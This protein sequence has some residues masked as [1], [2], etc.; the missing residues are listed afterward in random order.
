MGQDRV[1]ERGGQRVEDRGT[2]LPFLELTI[3]HRGVAVAFADAALRHKRMEEEFNKRLLPTCPTPAAL[4]FPHMQLAPAQYWQRNFFSIL[5]LSIFEA[6]GITEQRQHRYGMLLHGVRGIVTATDNVLDDEGKGSVLLTLRGGKVLK[7]VLVIL[8]ET[9]ILHEVL[10]D[11]CHDRE[12]MRDTWRGLL[13]ALHALG[14][15][16]S[17]EEHA[18]EHVLSPKALLDEVHRF[19]GGGLLQLA[20]IAP[21]L[22]EPQLHDKIALAK[23][24]VNHIGLSLQIID[25]LTDFEEDLRNRNHNM[26]RSWIVYNQPDGP[27]SDAE[28]KQ[29]P[30]EVLKA[31]EVHFNLATTEVLH[32]AVEMALAGF[33]RLNRIGHPVE[34][35]AARE[36]IKAMFKLRGLE[37]L[38]HL[39]EAPPE[40]KQRVGRQP[41]YAE[42]FPNP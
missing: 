37:R 36:L 3:A 21:E 12:A 27:C 17:A 41:N 13:H 20:F 22:N 32:M 33:E 19:R 14:A 11:L 25:D 29:L 39:Y 6:I 34:R 18:I 40:P 38:W 26:L 23:A 31:P 2:Y 8:M 35:S 7:N 9:G 1:D 15:E 5:F 10:A 42:Y 16:E 24:G 30:P 28:L 4:S